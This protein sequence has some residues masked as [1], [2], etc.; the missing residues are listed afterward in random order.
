MKVSTI[1]SCDITGDPYGT[2]VLSSSYTMNSSR[3]KKDYL[4]ENGTNV[5]LMTA[6]PTLVKDDLTGTEVEES[7]DVI[8]DDDYISALNFESG[9]GINIFFITE[10]NGELISQYNDTHP[11]PVTAIDKNETWKNYIN[12]VKLFFKDDPATEQTS[13]TK[14]YVT[15]AS[16]LD[17]K[18]FGSNHSGI[19][20]TY[21]NWNNGVGVSNQSTT[22]RTA[23][24]EVYVRQ[25]DKKNDPSENLY[26]SSTSGSPNYI[27]NNRYDG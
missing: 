18:C 9:K 20:P 12:T 6:R 26:V 24:I 25:T 5:Y 11:A 23:T 4:E 21:A 27:A 2:G 1:F 10:S 7:T 22:Q 3:V 8:V 17:K 16:N 15:M 13:D 19:E 14:S